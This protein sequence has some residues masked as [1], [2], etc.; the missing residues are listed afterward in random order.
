MAI[1]RGLNARLA[2][3]GKIKIGYKGKETTSK[4]GKKFQLPQRLDHFLITTTEKGPDG[5]FI[6]NAEIMQKLGDKP[7]ELSIRLL[8]DDPELNFNTS[9]AYYAGSKCVCRGD[10]ETCDRLATESGEKDT[11]DGKRKV[12]AGQ[13]Y[14]A[15][16]DPDTCPFLKDGK[17]K[18]NGILSCVLTD[19]PQLGGVYRF[20]THGWNSVS[21]I[22]ASLDFIKS[23]TNGVLVG[24]PLKLKIVKKA[25][26]EHGNVTT[27]AVS[28]DGESYDEMRKTAML[29]MRSRTAH[30]IDIKKLETEAKQAGF[31]SDTDDPEDIEAEYYP[32]EQK[33]PET[34]DEKN[35]SVLGN[36]EPFTPPETAPAEKQD[37]AGGQDATKTEPAAD[38]K[39]EKGGADVTQE[40]LF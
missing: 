8:F 18:V 11:A 34:I 10:G 30:G 4:G 3:V 22:Q 12:E 26:E 36:V 15:E 14:K 19:D 28:F 5:N 20:R 37:P 31:N 35:D 24:L 29:E 32:P 21:Q 39:E 40:D 27:V 1:K 33:A 9:F 6:P 17:C 13:R 25:T 7:K 38:E 16:C 23:V 2:E